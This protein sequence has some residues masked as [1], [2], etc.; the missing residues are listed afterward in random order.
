MHGARAG[1]P[2]GERNGAYRTGRHTKEAKAV[3]RWARGLARDMEIMT[4]TLLDRVGRR[5]PKR[6]RRKRHVRRALAEAKKA[7]G[8]QQ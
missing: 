5:P 4:A 6:L 7:K 3:G 8:E 1:A 2:A